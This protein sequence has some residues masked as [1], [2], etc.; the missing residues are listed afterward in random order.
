ML[1]LTVPKP[2][3]KFAGRVR[4]YRYLSTVDVALTVSPL[5]E[6]LPYRVCWNRTRR[7]RRCIRGTV[8]GYS[9]NDSASDSLEVRTR[10]MRRRTTFVWYVDGRRVASKRVRIST[11]R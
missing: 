3:E 4:V 7:P 10:G 8:D 11:P 6:H 5:G 1:S 9:W 2:S